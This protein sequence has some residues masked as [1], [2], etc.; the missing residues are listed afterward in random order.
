MNLALAPLHALSRLGTLRAALFRATSA[1]A[2]LLLGCAVAL[3]PEA[4]LSETA[5]Q[6]EEARQSC[7]LSDIAEIT[8]SASADNANE[9]EAARQTAIRNA[10][11]DGLQM[12][13]GGQVARSLQTQTESSLEGISQ[14]AREHVVVRSE[15]RVL[16]WEVLSEIAGESEAG[17]VFVELR[18]RVHVCVDREGRQP[19]VVAV[20]MV[21]HDSEF[22]GA[23]VAASVADAIMVHPNFTVVIRD[24]TKAYHDIRISFDH[25][26]VSEVVDNTG[27]ANTLAQF[28]GGGM[29]SQDALIYQLLTARATVRATRFLDELVVSE[30]VERRKRLSL[31]EETQS[32][33]LNLL[34]EAY[35]LAG[36]RLAGRLGA[37]ELDY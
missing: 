19:M 14:T 22:R 32:A 28:G 24:P 9:L 10:L 18:L 15:G 35:S 11:I 16:G 26:A 8:A 30:T 1:I 23:A 29:I 5:G 7:G 27:R 36:E 34:V 33:M 31:D 3:S 4:A 20:A 37:G 17:K 6:L 12:V 21:P 13:A 25:E 2:P